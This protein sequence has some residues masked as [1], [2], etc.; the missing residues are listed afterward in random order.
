M[1]EHTSTRPTLGDSYNFDFDGDAE[2]PD[3]ITDEVPLES[4]VPEIGEEQRFPQYGILNMWPESP[5]HLVI[6]L[7][8]SMKMTRAEIDKIQAGDWEDYSTE[9]EYKHGSSTNRQQVCQ[10]GGTL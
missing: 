4:S 7:K 1:T 6:I 5:H 10:D 9:W 2:T 3:E 8:M